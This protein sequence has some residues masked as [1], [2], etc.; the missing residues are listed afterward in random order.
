[1]ILLIFQTQNCLADCLTE[2][3]AKADH[4][5]TAVKTRKLLDVDIH[6]DYRTFMEHEGLLVN[7]LVIKNFM[8]TSEKEVFFQNTAQDLPCTNSPRRTISGDVCGVIQQHTMEHK[9]IE[10]A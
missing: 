2:A 4:L 7:H 6:P 9:R 10:Y 8:H 5:I 1:M 3:S